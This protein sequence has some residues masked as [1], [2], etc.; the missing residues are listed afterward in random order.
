MLDLIGNHIWQS[1]L[2]A[3]AAAFLTF[4]LLALPGRFH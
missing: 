4:S 1:T 3:I 2:F